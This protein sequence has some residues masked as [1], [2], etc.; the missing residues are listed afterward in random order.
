MELN[1]LMEK[2]HSVRSYT[3]MSPPDRDIEKLVKAANLAPSAGNLDARKI[4][5][6]RGSNKLKDAFH[7][8]W[9]SEAPYI[10]VFCADLKSV[11]KF[12]ERGKEL[13]CVQDAT[14]AATYSMLK[15]TEIGLGT[16]W[17]GSFDEEAL[18]VSAGLPEYLRP[19]AVLTVGYE[20]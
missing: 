2:R 15:A 14:I 12:G 18:K 16:C 3:S 4:F 1:E 11:E 9:I 5:T 20:K 6:F 8:S 13:Y 17:I 19:V 7:Q 10:L